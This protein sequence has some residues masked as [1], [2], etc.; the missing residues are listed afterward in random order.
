MLRRAS[1]FLSV[2]MCT[3][4]GYAQTAQHP[5]EVPEIKT[6]IDG[7]KSAGLQGVF[8]GTG[9][10]T[11]FVPSNAAVEKYGSDKFQKLQQP[12]NRD[13][14]IDLILYHIVPGEYHANAL[15]PMQ[16]K[17]INNKELRITSENGEIRV[18]GAKVVKAD[19]QG[20]NGTV[21]IIDSVLEP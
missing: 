10:F 5:L 13:A 14:F 20:P 16:L 21:Y 12:Q 2:L 17:T 19:Q 8:E 7:A 15:K 11:F 1:L 3:V 9:S 4:A 18:N 6:F